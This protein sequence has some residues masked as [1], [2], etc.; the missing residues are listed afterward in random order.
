MQNM[1]HQITENIFRN[2][3]F[4]LISATYRI[5][6]SKVMPIRHCRSH[7]LHLIVCKRSK[8]I[9]FR[10]TWKWMSENINVSIDVVRRIYRIK[11]IAL[12]LLQSDYKL[13]ALGVSMFSILFSFIVYVLDE[14]FD[15]YSIVHASGDRNSV[16][17]IS[18]SVWRCFV[19]RFGC[20]SPIFMRVKNE[21]FVFPSR[22]QCCRICLICDVNV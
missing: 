6:S 9:S 17:C 13:N 22:L 4:D 12:F 21:M 2:D 8:Y 5:R 16:P 7:E 1:K 14:W 10:R 15:L 19:W 3:I 18:S 11:L 20:P